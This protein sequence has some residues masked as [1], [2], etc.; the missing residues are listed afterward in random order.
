MFRFIVVLGM[1][2]AAFCCGAAAKEVSG[3]V[4]RIVDGDTFWIGKVKIRTCGINTPERG[5]VGYASASDRLSTFVKGKL[6]RCTQVGGGTVCDGRSKATNGDRIVAQCFVDNRDMADFMVQS[7]AACDWA[8]FSGG[9]Y[10]R[11]G[12]ATCH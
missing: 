11:N 1:S 2:S 6:V 8:K 4:T 5:E 3:Y 7:G 10:S 9:H 12:G